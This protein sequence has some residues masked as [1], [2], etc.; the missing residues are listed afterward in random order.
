MELDKLYPSIQLPVSRSTPMLS[1]LIKWHHTKS[2]N[3]HQVEATLFH[4]VRATDVIVNDME[5]SF[6]L[7]HVVDGM[8]KK[9]YEKRIS[10][11]LTTENWFVQKIYQETV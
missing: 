6:I 2:Y 11:I 4:P 3:I 9:R 5:W 1:P 8:I 10:F 7:G